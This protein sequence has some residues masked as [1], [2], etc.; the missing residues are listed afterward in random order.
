MEFVIRAELKDAEGCPIKNEIEI[1]AGL[2]PHDR[3][4]TC[5]LRITLP[6]EDTEV[7]GRL[8]YPEH[9]IF[10]FAGDLDNLKQEIKRAA[11]VH[12]L[13]QNTRFEFARN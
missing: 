8:V 10:L 2:S 3:M 11:S 12:A 13:L 6:T 9:A 4:A 7:T 1:I 5:V